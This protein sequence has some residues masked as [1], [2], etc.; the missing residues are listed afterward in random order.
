MTKLDR[1]LDVIQSDLEEKLL[2]RTESGYISS[3]PSNL[4]SFETDNKVLFR[5][6]ELHGKMAY[7]W[8]GPFV[9]MRSVGQLD[10]EIGV[11]GNPKK[12]PDC[13]H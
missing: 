9:V 13:S 5:V 4:R 7:S 10:Y 2:S 3:D 11:C 6:P 12:K 8:G 1:R